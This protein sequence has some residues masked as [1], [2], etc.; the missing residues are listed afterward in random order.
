MEK[1]KFL[2]ADNMDFPDDIFILHT[3]YPRFLLNVVTEE[4]EWL[5]PLTEKELEENKNELIQLV[6]EAFR[7]YDKEMERYEDE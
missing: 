4:V 5:D 6:E 3:G 2:L 1:P 7:F